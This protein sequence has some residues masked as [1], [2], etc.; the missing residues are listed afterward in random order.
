MKFKILPVAFR[1][2]FKTGKKTEIVKALEEKGI[3]TK[4]VM[5]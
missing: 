3:F 5:V 1:T 4:Q 2:C